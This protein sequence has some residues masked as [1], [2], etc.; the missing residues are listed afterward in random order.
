MI[1][2]PAQHQKP[3][4]SSQLANVLTYNCLRDCRAQYCISVHIFTLSVIAV[5]PVN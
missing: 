3:Q 1:N 4:Q 5:N 2:L